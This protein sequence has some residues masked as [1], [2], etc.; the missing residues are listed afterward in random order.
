[1][2]KIVLEVVAREHLYSNI[3]AEV[4]ILKVSLC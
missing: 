4:D 2:R 3:L 1:M